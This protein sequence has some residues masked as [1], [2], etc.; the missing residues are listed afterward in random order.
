MSDY[1]G[2]GNSLRG[3]ANKDTDGGR[4]NSLDGMGRWGVTKKETDRQAEN[5][6]QR[7]RKALSI[8][9][10]ETKGAERKKKKGDGVG[11]GG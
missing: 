2:M 8:V 10:K 3:S 11:G 9:L 4:D 1:T 6:E 7:R 5:R